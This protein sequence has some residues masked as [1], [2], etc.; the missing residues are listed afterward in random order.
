[1]KNKWF[2]VFENVMIWGV[3][4][5]VI[6]ASGWGFGSFLESYREASIVDDFERNLTIHRIEYT[7]YDIL[8]IITLME[9]EPRDPFAENG[10]AVG[11]LQMKPVAVDEVNRLCGTDFSYKDRYDSLKSK[12]MCIMFLA[13]ELGRYRKRFDRYPSKREL[14]CSWNRMS[15]FKDVYPKYSNRYNKIIRMYRL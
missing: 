14:A 11:L 8:E 13:H 9:N 5:T 1:M 6:G 15:I 4:L 12:Q 2:E 7:V 3:I 10:E